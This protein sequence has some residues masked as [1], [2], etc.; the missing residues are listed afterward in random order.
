M[1][2]KSQTRLVALGLV[3]SSALA[4]ALA[5][6]GASTAQ[7]DPLR[8]LGQVSFVVPPGNTN[9]I[10]TVYAEI[11]EPNLPTSAFDGQIFC[12][13]GDSYQVPVRVEMLTISDGTEAPYAI[14]WSQLPAAELGQTCLFTLGVTSQYAM[15]VGLQSIENWQNT[16]FNKVFIQGTVS[17]RTRPS[18]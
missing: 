14:E 13:D 10:T 4:L 9:P 7:A 11:A 15:S 12:A 5:V 16:S 6:G 3:C 17:T 2:T 18:Y 1:S 8:T